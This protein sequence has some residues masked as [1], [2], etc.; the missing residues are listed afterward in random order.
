MPSIV[1][2]ARVWPRRMRRA[3]AVEYLKEVHGFDWEEKT[4]RNRNAAGHDPRPQYLGTIPYYTPE[5]LDAFAEVAF[6]DESPVA[7]T[8]RRARRAAEVYS[9]VPAQAGNAL[10]V[11]HAK[12]EDHPTAA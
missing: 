11:G 6:T 5:R 2:A 10:L 9:A 3:L 1:P 12:K 4:L 8:R 7:E